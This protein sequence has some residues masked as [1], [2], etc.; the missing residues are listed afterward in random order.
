MTVSFMYFLGGA[1]IHGFTFVLLV[2][3]LVGTYSSVAI[4]A[5]LLLL[6][7]REA[8]HGCNRRRA[9]AR[10]AARP[11]E[12][13]TIRSLCWERSPANAQGRKIRIDHRRDPGR[14]PG[15]LCDRF[16]QRAC[17]PLEDRHCHAEPIG[18]SQPITGRGFKR[19]FFFGRFEPDGPH[20]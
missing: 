4:A 9:I 5:P 11:G 16:I 12:C 15:Y 8:A 7:P 10:W 1:G 3:I 13:L 6:G 2:G 19:F 20:R 17:K 18:S 14:Y